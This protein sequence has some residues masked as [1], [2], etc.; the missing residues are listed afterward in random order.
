MVGPL[1]DLDRPFPD[2]AQHFAQFFVGIAAIGED[3]PQPG[4]GAD[5]LDQ[6]SCRAMEVLRVSV[7]GRGLNWTAL[8]DAARPPKN[9]T[10]CG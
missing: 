6:N 2:L 1:N 4:V 9:W 5:D 7:V 3:S 8:G 10:V